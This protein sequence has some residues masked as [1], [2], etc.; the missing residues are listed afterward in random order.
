MKKQFKKQKK[1]K[2]KKQPHTERN[3]SNEKLLKLL[4]IY[5]RGGKKHRNTNIK[6]N[7]FNKNKLNKSHNYKTKSKSKYEEKSIQEAMYRKSN[8]IDVYKDKE[9]NINNSNK[10]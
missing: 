6:K 3:S 2:K 8:N 1:K 10:N 7:T 5:C 4:D 9:K